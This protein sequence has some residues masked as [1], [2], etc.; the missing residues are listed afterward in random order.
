MAERYMQRVLA[1]LHQ[2]QGGG[3]DE[4]GSNS[5]RGALGGANWFGD[6]SGGST[7]AAFGASW[8]DGAD[9]VPPELSAIYQAYIGQFM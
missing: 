6:A 7:S 8:G 5:E 2:Q 9:Q 3:D 1:A 4:A